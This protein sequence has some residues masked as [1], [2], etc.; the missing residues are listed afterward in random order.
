MVLA[1]AADWI[2]RVPAERALAAGPGAHVE[3]AARIVSVAVAAV[4]AAVVACV[5]FG[6]NLRSHSRLDAAR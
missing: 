5:L 3:P 4:A 6:G 2:I 1:A